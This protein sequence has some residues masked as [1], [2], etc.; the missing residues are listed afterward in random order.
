MYL[1]SAD[2][3]RLRERVRN[4]KGR[5]GIASPTQTLAVLDETP[6]PFIRPPTRPVYPRTEQIREWGFANQAGLYIRIVSTV[7]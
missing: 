7:R 1:E 5:R 6:C 3:K 2:K 4:T